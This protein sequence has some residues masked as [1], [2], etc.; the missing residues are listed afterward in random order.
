MKHQ[1][2]FIC[3]FALL[4]SSSEASAIK[5][6]IKSSSEKNQS[7]TPFYSFCFFSVLINGIEHD[8][9]GGKNTPLA[10]FPPQR[11]IF[12]FDDE[13]GTY[14]LPPEINDRFFA[15]LAYGWE[16][17]FQHD[18]CDLQ[19][20]RMLANK[21]PSSSIVL[22]FIATGEIIDPS[23]V[24]SFTKDAIIINHMSELVSPNLISGQFVIF[25]NAVT[26]QLMETLIYLANDYFIGW[27]GSKG[28]FYI[29]TK[30]QIERKM[31]KAEQF[32]SVNHTGISV[33]M[34]NTLKSELAP[35]DTNALPSYIK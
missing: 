4:L 2:L 31:K 28:G 18:E 15:L 1:Y 12:E 33:H 19:R 20:R 11:I 14:E 35:I 6:V 22:I 8:F 3:I 32:M 29:Q 25:K 24:T 13:M 27:D 34:W 9:F 5:I 16:K 21:Y 17:F 30:K 26:G 23:Q 10:T 7:V